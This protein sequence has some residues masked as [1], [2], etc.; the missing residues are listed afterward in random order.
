M[1]IVLRPNATKE[2]TDAIAKK[3]EGFGLGVHF[4]H[5]KERTIIGAIGSGAINYREH[6]TSMPG[7]ENIVPIMKPFKLASREL[8][9]GKSLVQVGTEVIGGPQFQ[10]IAGPCSVE[11]REML[12]QTAKEVKNAGASMLRGGAY[13]PRTSPY[14]FQGLGEEGLKLLAEAREITGLPVVTEVMDGR[15]IELTVRHADM[16]QVGARNMQNFRLLKEVGQTAKPVILKRGMSATVE[17]W[18]MSAEYIIAQGNQQVVLCERGVRTFET[19]TRNTLD[20][21]AVPVIKSLSHLPVMVD[22]SHATGRWDL[23]APMA[24]AALAAGADGVMIEVHPSPAEALCDG[25]QSL[26]PDKFKQLMDELRQIALV[27][28]RGL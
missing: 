5:G 9:D 11:N 2:Q 16:L 3:I 23:V 22:P 15:D 7:V 20:L 25:P 14:S 24:K 6:F 13:K 1:I 19:A 26:K 21:S 12:L 28:G 10:V 8:H 4:V 17:D 18:L 27:L